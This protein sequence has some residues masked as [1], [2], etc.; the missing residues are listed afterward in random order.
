MSTITTAQCQC[1]PDGTVCDPCAAA[2][3]AS[4]SS[5]GEQIDL[6]SVFPPDVR[7]GLRDQL[8]GWFT[9]LQQS[10]GGTR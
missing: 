7:Q 1:T 8:D 4:F 3:I 5:E 2:Q 9:T 6:S 10:Q